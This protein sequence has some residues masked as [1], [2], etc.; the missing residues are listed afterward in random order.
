MDV[1]Q[2]RRLVAAL[3]AIGV[4]V[5]IIVAIASAG[6][7]DDEGEITPVEDTSGPGDGPPSKAEYIREADATCAEAN[8]ALANL[9]VGPTA[10][11]PELLADQQYEYTRSQLEQLQTLTRPQEDRAG[12]NA[13]FSAF[14]DQ[15]EALQKQQLATERADDAALAEVSTE[16]PAAQAEVRAAAADYGFK[17]CG[18][19]GSPTTTADGTDAGTDTGTAVPPAAPAPTETPAAPIEPAEVPVAPAEPAAPPAD[20]GGATEAPPADTGDGTAEAPPSGDGG[21]GGTGGTGT[22]GVSP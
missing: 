2:R 5:I 22:G 9:S 14:R 7:D 19:E 17:E 20:T 16:L 12:L 1:Y 15:L 10:D 11:D 8:A 18:R 13:F 21:T 3:S 6:G 4:L